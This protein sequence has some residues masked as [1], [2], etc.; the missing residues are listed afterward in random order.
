MGQS[1]DRAMSNQTTFDANGENGLIMGDKYLPEELLIEI[2]IYTDYKTLL[3]CQLVCKRW[4]DLLQEYVWR[5]KAEM[6]IDRS[7]SSDK[8][9]PWYVYYLICK[10]RP[11]ERNLLKNH[12]GQYGVK[13]HWKIVAEGGNR[14]VVENPPVGVPPLSANVPIFEGKQCCFATSYINCCKVQKIDLEEEGLHPLLLDNLQPPVQVS[15]WY[16]CRWD[17]PAIYEFT[18]ELLDKDDKVIDSFQH[19][20]SIEGENQNQWLREN[21]FLP[22]RSGQII[23]GR[24]LW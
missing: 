3:K 15:E 2:F 21:K 7:L 5:K 10:K 18:A 19:R 4:K 23:L 6:I 1:H 12:S 22:W 9:L 17:C 8:D 13:K 11:F 24:K 14:W 16:S 20:D